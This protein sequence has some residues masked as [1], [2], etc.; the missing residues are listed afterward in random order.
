MVEQMVEE[1]RVEEGNPRR[2]E[3]LAPVLDEAL[4]MKQKPA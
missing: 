1:M 3:I 4:R 2:P